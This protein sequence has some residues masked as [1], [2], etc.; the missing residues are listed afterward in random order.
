MLSRRTLIKSAAASL[1]VCSPYLIIPKSASASFH[2]SV[3]GSSGTTI[4]SLE[5]LATRNMTQ[6]KPQGIPTIDWSH[7]V[8][9]GLI[10]DMFDLGNGQYI[11]LCNGNK[12]MNFQYGSG[13]SGGAV[14][15]LKNGSTQYGTATL[16]PG[17]VCCSGFGQPGVGSL[18]ELFDDPSIQ[19]A[20]SLNLLPIGAGNT[21]ATGFMWTGPLDGQGSIHLFGRTGISAGEISPPVTWGFDQSGN[22]LTLQANCLN[23]SQSQVQV[24]NNYTMVPGAYASLLMTCQNTSASPGTG[25]AYFAANGVA[26]GNTA[27]VSMYGYPPANYPETDLQLGA[28]YHYQSSASQKA[29]IGYI[30]WGR[31]WVRYLPPTE[32]MFVH[33]HP[34]AYYN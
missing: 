5:R 27:G 6:V 1:A 8:T 34:Y 33:N 12:P 7:P 26:N 19:N 28:T 16:W 32:W 2:G 22:T 9:N 24:G 18:I 3:V 20:T 29:W 11:N 30:Y 21:I 14:K 31:V 10:V 4:G 15:N 17:L 23:P 13:T 25:T